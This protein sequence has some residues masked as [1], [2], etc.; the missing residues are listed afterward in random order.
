VIG[1]FRAPATIRFGFTPLYTSFGDVWGAVEILE[2][3]LRSGAW[4]EQRFS[5]RAA[6]T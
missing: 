5:V 1:D 4:R 6:V 2:D 3:V